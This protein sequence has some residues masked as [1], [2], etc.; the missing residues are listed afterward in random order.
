MSGAPADALPIKVW[1][2]PVR[3][4]H[5]AMVVC[6]VA[7]IVTVNIG[8]PSKFRNCPIPKGNDSTRQEP[9]IFVFHRAGARQ[10]AHQHFGQFDG[11]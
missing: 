7:S 3:I 10:L 8:G 9:A 5:W 2:L 6:L 1:D 4:V 11:G